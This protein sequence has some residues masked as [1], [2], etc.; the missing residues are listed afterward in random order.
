M[1]DEG[2][3]EF[4]MIDLDTGTAVEVSTEEDVNLDTFF[5]EDNSESDEKQSLS[6]ALDEAFS[7]LMTPKKDMNVN[8]TDLANKESE[9]DELTSTISQKAQKM[10]FDLSFLNDENDK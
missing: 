5:E 8:E 2:D 1:P 4:E 9:I 10:D 3:D 7:N 6:D